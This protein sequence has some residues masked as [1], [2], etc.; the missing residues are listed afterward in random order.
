[1]VMTKNFAVPT[2]YELISIPAVSVALL[3]LMSAGPIL[4]QSNINVYLFLSDRISGWI[5]LRL[6]SLNTP[7]MNTLV[8]FVLWAVVGALV[9]LLLW[10][11]ISAVKDFRSDI[12]PFRRLMAPRGAASKGSLGLASAR[13]VLRIV[14]A[15]VLFAWTLYVLQAVIPYAVLLFGNALVRIDWYSPLQFIIATG[16][17]AVSAYVFMILSRLT[18]LKHRL[19]RSF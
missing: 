7:K 13:T 1:M 17:T 2:K 12:S 8:V 3:F 15:L 14:A 5:D 19:F 16:L 4:K 11:V 9:Y 10:G 6:D 18:F